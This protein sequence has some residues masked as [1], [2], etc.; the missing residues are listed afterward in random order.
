[1]NASWKT[2]VGGLLMAAGQLLAP[3]L[4]A[5][6]SWVG[7]ALSGLGALVLGLNARDNNVST[8]QARK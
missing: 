6:L 4:P 3:G 1:M 7:A 2:S 5:H 8:E